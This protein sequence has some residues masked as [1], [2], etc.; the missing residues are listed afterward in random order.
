[1]TNWRLILKT[2]IVLT[3]LYSR[4]TFYA[5]AY[6]KIS[7]T[8]NIMSRFITTLRNSAD[9][10]N[11]FSSMTFAPHEKS[12]IQKLQDFIMGIPG[13]RGLVDEAKHIYK[14]DIPQFWTELY[15]RLFS[16]ST[17]YNITGHLTM[18]SFFYDT[19]MLSVLLYF[20]YRDHNLSNV[21]LIGDSVYKFITLLI[22]HFRETPIERLSNF[23]LSF[24]TN[25]KTMDVMSMFKTNW[26]IVKD[27][28]SVISTFIYMSL[29]VGYFLWNKGMTLMPKMTEAKVRQQGP[30]Q[31]TRIPSTAGDTKRQ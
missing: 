12:N 19:L 7:N 22:Y 4:F 31:Q 13:L 23:F 3:F 2:I 8:E 16:Q 27:H 21:I 11:Y 14:E 20:V 1:M 26:E 30:V 24:F 25:F 6:P 10:V 5:D 9:F 15:T 18:K 28:R 29:V 17:I